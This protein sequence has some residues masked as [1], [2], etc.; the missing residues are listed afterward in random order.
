[1]IRC[2]ICK[3][4]AAGLWYVA[5]GCIALRGTPLQNLCRQHEQSCEP[6]GIDEF[7]K[8][9]AILVH[10]YLTDAWFPKEGTY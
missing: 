4:V 3:D 5:G 6:I 1:M 2:D 8:M 10:D 7:P 9:G